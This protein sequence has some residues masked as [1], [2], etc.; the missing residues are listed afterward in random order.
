MVIALLKEVT[1]L[2]QTLVEWSDKSR[3]FKLS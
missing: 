1:A 3:G 2:R